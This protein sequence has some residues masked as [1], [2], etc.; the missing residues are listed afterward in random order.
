MTDIEPSIFVQL[1]RSFIV[2]LL[3]TNLKQSERD[4]FEAALECLNSPNREVYIKGCR[5]EI[6]E[7]GVIEIDDSAMVSEGDGGAYV[8]AW[9]WVSNSDLLLDGLELDVN[10]ENLEDGESDLT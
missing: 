5:A 1:D 3:S 10:L 4:R 6:H 8:Q 2:R 7:E 9:V